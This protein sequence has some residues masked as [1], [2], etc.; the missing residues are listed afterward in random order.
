[1]IRCPR[2]APA[3]SPRLVGQQVRGT[4]VSHNIME[5]ETA[6][7]ICCRD[8]SRNHEPYLMYQ[9]LRGKLRRNSDNYAQTQNSRLISHD[10]TPPQPHPPQHPPFPPSSKPTA[11]SSQLLP[12]PPRNV[13]ARRV[14]HVLARRPFR[15]APRAFESGRLKK[16]SGFDWKQ[17]HF[18]AF[19]STATLKTAPFDFVALDTAFFGLVSFGVAR[20]RVAASTRSRGPLA[21][22]T[23]RVLSIAPTESKSER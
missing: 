6:L 11:C 17:R 18:L 3:V 16:S 2:N 22:D 10:S 21:D 13:H 14:H 15:G 8:I 4:N 19:E 5:D 1:M 23:P 7:E 12:E 20:P 9:Q